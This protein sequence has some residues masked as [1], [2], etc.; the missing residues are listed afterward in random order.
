MFKH[1]RRKGHGMTEEFH[2][3]SNTTVTKSLSVV[4]GDFVVETNEGER[5]LLILSPVD[6]ILR[7]DCVILLCDFSQ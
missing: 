6:A 1:H 3:T 4:L 5:S 2:A 7:E